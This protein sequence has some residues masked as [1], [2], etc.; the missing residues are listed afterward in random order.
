MPTQKIV[1]ATTGVVE[2]IKFP[3]ESLVD[4]A[5]AINGDKAP[6]INLEH[7]PHYMPLGKV[8]AAEVMDIGEQAALVGINDDTHSAT[9]T[10]HEP[11]GDRIVEVTFPNDGRPFIQH[12]EGTFKAPLT[13]AVDSANF[14][15][16]GNLRGFL[17]A[18]DRGDDEVASSSMVRRSLTPE[19]LIQFAVSD[20]VFGGIL[21]W[22]AFRGEKFLRY[23]VDETA[24]KMGDAI[25]DKV[26]EKLKKWLGAYNELRST[27]GRAVT[28]HVIINVEPQIN[29]LTRSHDIDQCTHIGIDSLCRQME[30]HK[31]LLADADSATFARTA[32]EEEWKFLYIT[33]KSGKVITTEECYKATARRREEIAKTIPICLCLEHKTTRG[34]RHYETTAI[35]T[36]LDE[37]GRFQFKFNTV[38]NDFEDYELTQVTL[39]LGEETE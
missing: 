4:A 37:R 26:S 3:R 5:V 30:L 32:Q 19:P 24:R 11:T 10:M 2:G 17:N 20:V 27:D 39:L 38:P 29:L 22:L 25:S 13:I 21:V 15:D 7:D 35:A 23:T 14:D 36:K 33:T 12:D 31:D 9:P 28:S 8:R 16:L 18:P 34:E 6:R 1:L